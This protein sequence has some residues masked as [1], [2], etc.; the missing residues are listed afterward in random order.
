[1]T[2]LP[3]Q[4]RLWDKK[5]GKG[6][7]AAF[8][9]I[10]MEFAVYA[11]PLMLRESYMLDL[12]C[13]VGSNARY[14]AKRG[15]HVEAVDISS[16][17]LEQ[18]KE[19]A[20]K[21]IHYQKVDISK[22]LP[23][24]DATFDVVFAHLSLHYFLDDTTREII[25]EINRVLRPGGQFF[26]RCKSVDSIRERRESTEVEPNVY[27]H[28]ETGHVRHLFSK[29]YAREITQGSFKLIELEAT[30]G[31]YGN[32]ESAFIEYYGKKKETE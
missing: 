31:T 32:T 10:D 29:N 5:H 15:H 20:A 1:M 30:K 9:D 28:N 11:E 12:G 3:D 18:N 7:H 24:Q 4:E 27:V 14:F 23:Y 2:T 6:E 22:P 19:Q 25:R 16:V 13:G 26:F 8:R 21:G 17:V